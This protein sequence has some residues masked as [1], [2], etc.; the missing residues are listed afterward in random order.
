ME[1]LLAPPGSLAGGRGLLSPPKKST[2]PSATA[3][4]IPYINC[5]ADT[6]FNEILLLQNVGDFFPIAE[7]GLL[8]E[9]RREL[10]KLWTDSYEILSS[11]GMSH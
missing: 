7:K 1:N 2:T 4:D 3:T 11:G 5:H 10:K 8:Y 6:I 9:S